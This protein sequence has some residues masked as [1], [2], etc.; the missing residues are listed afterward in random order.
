MLQVV[1]GPGSDSGGHAEL[2]L[3]R[4]LSAE[5]GFVWRLLRRL[6]VQP[7]RVDDEAQ[8]VFVIMAAK[9]AQIPAHAERSF[10]V[11]T[12]MRVAANARRAQASDASGAKI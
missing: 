10:L 12:A 2:R 5:F 8:H 4:L 6:G 7:A 11:G 3:A 9:L 1:S